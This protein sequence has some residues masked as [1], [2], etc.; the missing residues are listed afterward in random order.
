MDVSPDIL[1]RTPDMISALQAIEAANEML[2]AASDM[3][4]SGDYCGSFEQSRAVLR[5]AASALLFKDGVIAPSFDATTK[6]IEK[7][8]PETFPLKDWDH[9]ERTVTGDG[10]GLLNMMIRMSGKQTGLSEAQH[11]LKIATEFLNNVKQLV[12]V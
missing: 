9:I 8:Y 7:R 2:H 11:A 3:M 5:T 6:H 4:D 10:P 12:Y 1:R